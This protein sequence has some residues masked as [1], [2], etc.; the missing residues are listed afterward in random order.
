MK[1]FKR[2][3]DSRTWGVLGKQETF[4]APTQFLGEKVPLNANPLDSWDYKKSKYRR[5][6][7]VPRTMENDGQQAGVVPQGT[8]VTPTPTPSSTSIPLTPSPTPT[9]TGTPTPTTTPTPT[10][11]PAPFDADAAAYLSV[12]LS[13]GGTLSP[14]ISAAT[15]TLFTQ[16]KSNNLYSKIDVMYPMLGSNAGGN[17]ID[18]KN[19]VSGGY[20]IQWFGGMLFSDKGAIGNGSNAYGTTYYIANVSSNPL[21][22]GW[23]I[24]MYDDGNFAANTGE[25][26]NS[27]AFD[28][29]YLSTMRGE[30]TTTVGLYGYGVGDPRGS[31]SIPTASDYT[32]NYAFT[33]NSSKLKSLYRNYNVGSGTTTSLT[34]AGTAA[35][36]NQDI[37]VFVLNLN[38][39]PYIGNYWSGTMSFYWIGESMTTGEVSTLSTIINTFQTTLGR[40]T[41]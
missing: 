28:G 37:Y 30:T 11:T 9:Q 15:N 26:Y 22:Y 6:D 8:P 14:T 12:V 3:V 13:S 29:T 18:A 24:Y 32:G 21:N 19:P 2:K 39:S 27:G 20:P 7:L 38:G 33:F 35:L 23:G 10:S 36:S 5:I 31:L 17:G 4:Y 41:Y 40:N 1:N 16:L 25:V 34:M